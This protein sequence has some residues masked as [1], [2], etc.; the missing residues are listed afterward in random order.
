MLFTNCEKPRDKLNLYKTFIR[1]GM[2]MVHVYFRKLHSE[3]HDLHNATTFGSHR[4]Q[5][6]WMYFDHIALDF[7]VIMCSI[8][9]FCTRHFLFDA[10]QPDCWGTLKKLKK[11]IAASLD[12]L[13]QF[14]TWKQIE[15]FV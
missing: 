8:D 3:V 15:I 13:K 1:I 10:V 5:S 7:N 12:C 2:S 14:F 6:T 11:I 9:F 4:L